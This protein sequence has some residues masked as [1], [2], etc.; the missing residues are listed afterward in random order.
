MAPGPPSGLRRWLPGARR[1]LPARTRLGLVAGLIL[2]EGALGTWGFSRLTLVKATITTP[3]QKLTFLESLFR[4]LRLYTLDI[5]P[6]GGGFASGPNWQILVALGLAAFLVVRA[7]L[8]IGGDRLRRALTRRVLRGHVIVCGAGV[9]GASFAAELAE[10]H[11]VI[12]V[13]TDPGAPGMRGPLGKHEWRLVG[14]AVQPDALLAAGVRRAN[15]V[16]VVTGHDYVNSQI[17]SAVHALADLPATWFK[18][19]L[20]V[21]VQVE[22]LRRSQEFLEEEPTPIDNARG[23]GSTPRPLPVVTAFSANAIAADALLVDLPRKLP[24]GAEAPLLSDPT[25]HLILAGD[26][27]LIDAIVLAVLRRWRVPYLRQLEAAPRSGSLETALPSHD[28]PAPFRISIY[29]P[30]AVDGPT[31]S[32]PAGDPSRACSSSR[33]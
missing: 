17:V 8:A 1:R 28:L 26:H 32:G 30:A 25:P 29:G 9:H 21:L 7:L 15:W 14:D 27:P 23:R 11:D 31:E 16:V 18:D 19:R 4:A 3:A 24:R 5:G 10:H 22:E 33:L 13:D 6:A 12:V 20:H 2:A